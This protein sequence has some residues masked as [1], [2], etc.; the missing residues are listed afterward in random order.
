[1][2]VLEDHKLVRQSKRGDR[3]AFETL[4]ERYLDPMLTIAMNL[5]GDSAAAEDVVQEVFVKFVE[6]L[7]RFTLRGSLKGFLAT[8]VANRARD[9]LRQRARRQD[10]PL[11]A[12]AGAID[13]G[14]GPI[15]LVES[16]EQL[17]ILR[18]GLAALPYEQREVITLRHWGGLKFKE[19]AACQG[20][21]VQTVQSRYA[22]GMEKLRGLLNGE[23]TE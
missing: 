5:L 20:A 18:N 1:M 22:Y 23:V 8:C 3:K 9:V 4:Y 16:S 12:A 10:R 13:G 15:A 11:E 2:Q 14:R 19:I 7:P 21:A 6:S 17:Q